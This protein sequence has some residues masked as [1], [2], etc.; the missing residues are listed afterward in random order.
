MSRNPDVP[1]RKLP[2]LL[3]S[4]PVLFLDRVVSHVVLSTVLEIP[5]MKSRSSAG[6]LPPPVK[7]WDFDFQSI[8]GRWIVDV[9]PTIEAKHYATGRE[10]DIRRATGEKAGVEFE[11]TGTDFGENREFWSIL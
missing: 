5:I 7:D 1:P 6:Q 2:P 11:M 3:P 4:G 8:V 10:R 9:E